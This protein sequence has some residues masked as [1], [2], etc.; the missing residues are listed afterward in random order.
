MISRLLI[1]LVFFNLKDK[2]NKH[3]RSAYI[4]LKSI[5]SSRRLFKKNASFISSILL[6][7]EEKNKITEVQ[8][9]ALRRICLDGW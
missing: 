8:L 4:L 6:Y 2:I 1:R 7:F 9:K 3:N 5:I